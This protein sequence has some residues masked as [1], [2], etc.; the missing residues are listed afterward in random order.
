MQAARARRTKDYVRALQRAGVGS[1]LVRSVQL[2]GEH[3]LV[4][5]VGTVWHYQPRAARQEAAQ[6]LWLL[7]ANLDSPGD[8]DTARIKL[9]ETKVCKRGGREPDVGGSRIWVAD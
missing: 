2:D 8:L 6:S 1:E 4:I 7:W 5:T 3:T 9:V